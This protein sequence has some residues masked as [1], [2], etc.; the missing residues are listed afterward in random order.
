M[1][2]LVDRPAELARLQVLLDEVPVV[3]VLGARQVGKATLARLLGER[4]GAAVTILYLDDPRDLATSH[5]W[6]TP[7]SPWVSFADSRSSMRSSG[8]PSSSRSSTSASTDDPCPPVSWRSGARRRTCSV[9][10]R[11]RSRAGWPCTT[12]GPRARRGRRGLP[13]ARLD[14]PRARPRVDVERQRARA[15]LRRHRQDRAAPPR[16]AR[17]DVHGAT[18]RPV[19]GEP[20]QAP[21]QGAQGGPLQRARSPISSS[22]ADGTVA[23]SR[24]STPTAPS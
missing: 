4:M 15:R 22:S 8:P 13:P 9:R 20:R 21:G 19:A 24:S 11:S 18:A 23:G 16:R 7:R 14:N 3:G 10:D 17:L 5:G 12:S 1:H 6:P 2:D